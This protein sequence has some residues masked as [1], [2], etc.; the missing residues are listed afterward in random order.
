[1]GAEDVDEEWGEVFP[2]GGEKV[3]CAMGVFDGVG[4]VVE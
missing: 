2:N 1:V 4:A 3:A